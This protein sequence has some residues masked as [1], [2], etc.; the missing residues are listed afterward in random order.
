MKSFKTIHFLIPV[1]SFKTNLTYK[2]FLFFLLIFLTGTSIVFSQNE[3]SG[4]APVIPVEGFIITNSGDTIQGK[5][6]YRKFKENFMSEIR[7]TGLD[8][9]NTIYKA[10]DIKGMGIR[11]TPV[12]DAEDYVS[13]GDPFWDIYECKPSPKKKAMVFMNRYTNG[14]IKIFQNRSSLAHFGNITKTTSKFD[15]I[16]FEFSSIDGLY[17]GPSFK[18]SYETIV[19]KSWRSSYYFEKDKGE[20]KKISKK[21]FDAL[22]SELFGDCTKIKEEVKNNPDLKNYKNFVLIVNLYNQLC[23]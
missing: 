23:N 11:I 12:D 7:F 3:Y 8:E 14:R 13:L 22:W 10:G 5:I 20:I 4:M 2:I 1:K 21:N 18:V 6:K 15:G 16:Y 17:I 9:K 19:S